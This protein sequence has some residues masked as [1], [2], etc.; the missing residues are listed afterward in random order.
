M[1]TQTVDL[2]L[3]SDPNL[4]PLQ[5]THRLAMQEIARTELELDLSPRE[6]LDRANRALRTYHKAAARPRKAACWSFVACE[7]WNGRA[8]AIR[9]GALVRGSDE[10]EF[11]S[12]RYEDARR[13]LAWCEMLEAQGRADVRC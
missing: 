6:G 2:A 5:Q 1:Q 12:A 13:R 3:D 7:L 9:S 11:I 8:D 4:T 10:Y